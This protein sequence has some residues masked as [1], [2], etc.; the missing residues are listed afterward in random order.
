MNW[1]DFRF[2]YSVGK[3]WYCFVRGD[4]YV[5]FTKKLLFEDTSPSIEYIGKNYYWKS[6]TML[7]KALRKKYEIACSEL[8]MA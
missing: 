3:G 4:K 2:N 6:L 1:Q 7:L 5:Y 8:R